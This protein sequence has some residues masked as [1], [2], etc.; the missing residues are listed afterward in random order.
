MSV[1]NNLKLK[2]RE[3]AEHDESLKIDTTKFQKCEVCSGTGVIIKN[4][5]GQ[6]NSKASF[7]CGTCRGFGYYLKDDSE[8]SEYIGIAYLGKI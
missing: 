6:Y 3:C 7:A 5:D 8:D 4:S 1:D 2:K